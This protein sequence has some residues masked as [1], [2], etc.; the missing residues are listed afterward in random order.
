MPAPCPPPCW[1]SY[2]VVGFD[3]GRGVPV[4]R[5]TDPIGIRAVRVLA[6]CGRP[7]SNDARI[8][9]AGSRCGDAPFIFPTT[10]IAG[11]LWGDS[12]RL[13]HRHQGVDIFSGTD[14]NVTP[15]VAVYPAS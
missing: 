4:S 6:G 8:I 12:F 3:Y 14:V 5:A 15:V 10:G 2:P 11:F 1:L 13:G 9:K 7:E